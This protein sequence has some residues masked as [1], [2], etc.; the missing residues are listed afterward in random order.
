MGKKIGQRPSNN[1]EDLGK[2]T[3]NAKSV[4]LKAFEGI[5][6]EELIDYHCH[7]VGFGNSGTGCCIRLENIANSLTT[8]LSAHAMLN[9]AGITDTK[10]ADQVRLSLNTFQQIYKVRCF[11]FWLMKGLCEQTFKVHKEHQNAWEVRNPRL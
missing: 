10:T 2:M 4:M 5:K 1:P 6:K 8:K 11:F 7:V 9:A 3:A